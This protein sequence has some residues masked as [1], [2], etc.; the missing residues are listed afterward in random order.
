MA[1]GLRGRKKG[2]ILFCSILFMLIVV[3]IGYMYI[4][5]TPRYSLYQFKR[6]ILKHDAEGALV[7]LD[8][9]SIVDNM[10]KDIFHE[11]DKQKEPPKNKLEASMRGI[12]KD[13]IMQNLP[14][15]KEQLREQLKSAIISYNDRAALDNL[16]RANILGLNI[17]MDGNIALVKI[18]GKDKVAFKMAKSPE[19][20]WR[21]VAFNVN[22]LIV[23]GGK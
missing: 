10:V 13:V 1:E 18:R 23:P 15:I 3:G 7:Y 19:G 16:S 5:A 20:R 8:T 14:S 12:G 4:Q 9:D 6:T 2:P 22:E 17:T 21:I 11:P